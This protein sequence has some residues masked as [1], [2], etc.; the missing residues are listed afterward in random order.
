[1]VELERLGLEQL[2]GE[3]RPLATSPENN[4]GSAGDWQGGV[5]ETAMKLSLAIEIPEEL[6]SRLRQVV[7]AIN[8]QLN[9]E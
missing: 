4:F 2:A 8:P 9:Q 3:I 7:E 5:F 1:M 6:R